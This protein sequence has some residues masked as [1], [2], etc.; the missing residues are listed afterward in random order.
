MHKSKP[1]GKLYNPSGQ[2]NP[3]SNNKLS[4]SASPAHSSTAGG[5]AHVPCAH[6]SS[7][8]MQEKKT[9]LVTVPGTK[10]QPGTKVNSA[11]LFLLVGIDHQAQ[12]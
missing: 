1:P 9:I 8:G 3:S 2:L 12:I 10:V 11:R 4:E 6:A 7:N 5:A